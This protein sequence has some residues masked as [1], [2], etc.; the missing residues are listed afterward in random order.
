MLR[1]IHLSDFHLNKNNVSD[2]NSY[3]KDALF[4]LLKD[5]IDINTTF[6]I[7]TGDLV[8][9]GGKDYSSIEDAFNEFKKQVITPI[10]D[11][12]SLPYEHFIITP[13]N[14]DTAAVRADGKAC[15]DTSG[16]YRATC[17]GTTASTQVRNI[18][19]WEKAYPKSRYPGIKTLCDEF[20]TYRDRLMTKGAPARMS[21][22]SLDHPQWMSNYCTTHNSTDNTYRTFTAGGLNWLAINYEFY[23]RQVVQE[24][25]KNHAKTN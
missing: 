22:S 8:D 5:K 6:F 19:A 11:F 9:K 13:G 18:S 12:F 16:G 17:P 24:W 3:V 7:C 15:Q 4:K 1:I 25:M 20:N 10:C 14:H 2:W 21:S 23:P